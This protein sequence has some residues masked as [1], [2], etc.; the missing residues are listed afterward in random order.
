VAEV[1]GEEAEGEAVS[2]ERPDLLYS[3]LDGEKQHV[4][5]PFGFVVVTEAADNVHAE[6]TAYKVVS[7]FADDHRPDGLEHYLHAEIKWDS[8][9]HFNFGEPRNDVSREGYLHICGASNF[10]AHADLMWVLYDLAFK[11]MGR[12][13]DDEHEWRDTSGQENPAPGTPPTPA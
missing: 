12:K 2:A 5:S 6:F 3:D 11:A 4:L 1:G 13:P 7:Q 9:A 8:C 10:K